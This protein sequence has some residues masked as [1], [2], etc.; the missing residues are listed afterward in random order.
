[1]RY[2]MPHHAQSR[3]LSRW[4]LIVAIGLSG[5]DK[6][7]TPEPLLELSGSTMGTSYHIKLVAQSPGLPETASIEDLQSRI[8]QRLATINGMMSTY[9]PDSDLSLFNASDQTDWI[10]VPAPLIGV[11]ETAQTISVM[12]KGMFDVTVGPLVELWGFGPGERTTQ[13]PDTEQIEK[14]LENVGYKKLA[15]QVNP[16]A[17]KKTVPGLHLDLSAIAKGYAVDQIAELLE[18]SGFERYLVEIGGELRANGHKS[19]GRPWRV[20]IERPDPSGRSVQS[21]IELRNQAMATSGD[22]RNFFEH[23]G[24]RYSHTIDPTSGQSVRQRLASV[25]VLADECMIA[26]GLATALLAMGEQ[27]GLELAES[28]E[29]AAMFIVRTEDGLQVLRSSHFLA[30]SGPDSVQETPPG[31]ARD[32][33]SY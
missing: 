14:A 10:P 2:P 9:R 5:C 17:L 30:D 7:P 32:P 28:H 16:P 1:M 29:I 24:Q 26:D 31:P 23:D 21:I 13:P 11:V 20:A 25:T 4:L 19:G 33:G 12:S 27:A 3:S 8:D 22:Y 15:V 18:Q 6:A